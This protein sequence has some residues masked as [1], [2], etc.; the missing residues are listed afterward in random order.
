MCRWIGCVGEANRESGVRI[1]KEKSN[2]HVAFPTRYSLSS[3]TRRP[4]RGNR[5]RRCDGYAGAS[6]A[7]AE[8][9][10]SSRRPARVSLRALRLPAPHGARVALR[11]PRCGDLCPGPLLWLPAAAQLPGTERSH[12]EPL[13]AASAS[14]PLLAHCRWRSSRASWISALQHEGVSSRRRS[15]ATLGAESKRPVAGKRHGD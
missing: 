11:H 5:P 10:P 15:L 14:A 3:P 2:Y 8:R 13:K 1:G 7:T 9:L 6:S 12:L 4:P